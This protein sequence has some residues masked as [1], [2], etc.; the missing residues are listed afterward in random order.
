MDSILADQ[1]EWLIS[2]NMEGLR[3]KRQIVLLAG[4]LADQTVP[5]E[6]EQQIANLSK[7]I[8]LEEVFDA[9]M[10]PLNAYL[11]NAGDKDSTVLDISGL[12]A[13]IEATRQALT[14]CEPVNQ[15]TLITWLMSRA[16]EKKLLSKIRGT[17]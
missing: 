8:A 4:C 5:K 14:D 6:V 12:M 16:R 1:F 13:Q 2:G 17:R 9:L 15:A 10:E 11:R 7:R 3:F